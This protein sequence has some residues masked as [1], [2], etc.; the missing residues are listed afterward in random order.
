MWLFEVEIIYLQCCSNRMYL[1]LGTFCILINITANKH[2]HWW[3]RH[4]LIL[5]RFVNKSLYA[6]RHLLKFL[7][8]YEQFGKQGLEY[9]WTWK[10]WLLKSTKN[11]ISEASKCVIICIDAIVY[12]YIWYMHMWRYFYNRLKF[13]YINFWKDFA[14]QKYSLSFHWEFA[15]FFNHNPYLCK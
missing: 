8:Y 12:M 2:L 9:S 14:T 13:V 15:K 6:V 11:A 10:M 5:F 3:D 1:F 4:V 7:H